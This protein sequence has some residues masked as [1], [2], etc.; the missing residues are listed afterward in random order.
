MDPNKKITKKFTKK[1]D[2]KVINGQYFHRKTGLMCIV[3][4]AQNNA[5]VKI[6][7]IVHM[8][9]TCFCLIDMFMRKEVSKDS[10]MGQNIF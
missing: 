4:S 5:C 9:F 10:T 2:S 6:G 7:N 1:F 3:L 8:Y